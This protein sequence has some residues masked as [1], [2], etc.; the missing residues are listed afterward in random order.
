MKTPELTLGQQVAYYHT[1]DWTQPAV[2]TAWV[3][4][5]PGDAVTLLVWHQTLGP[6]FKKAVHYAHDQA[7]KPNQSCWDTLNAAEDRRR[8][9][10]DQKRAQAQVEADQSRKRLEEEQQSDKSVRE[11][12][13]LLHLEKRTYKEIVQELAQRGYPLWNVNKVAEVIKEYKEAEQVGA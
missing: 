4:E 3:Y 7:R 6:F 12:I 13:I 5:M 8:R 11:V 2:P 9:A 1:G 10:G